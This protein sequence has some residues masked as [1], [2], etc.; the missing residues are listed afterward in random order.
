MN[1]LRLSQ[2]QEHMKNIWTSMLLDAT[3]KAGS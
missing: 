1:H 2:F 3:V